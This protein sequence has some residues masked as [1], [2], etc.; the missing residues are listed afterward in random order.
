MPLISM[1]TNNSIT[2]ITLVDFIMPTQRTR[3]LISEI[4]IRTIQ[5]FWRRNFPSYQALFHRCLNLLEICDA[6]IPVPGAFLNGKHLFMGC[7][8][9]PALVLC[10]LT[11]LFLGLLRGDDPPPL[12]LL[13]LL[14]AIPQTSSENQ[15]SRNNTE[16][17]KRNPRHVPFR[18][19]CRD[20]HSVR[21]GGDTAPCLFAIFVSFVA[22][23]VPIY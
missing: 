8:L 16:Y 2:F 3:R 17:R 15:K 1:R 21:R 7:L 20:R 5:V 11:R 23:I 6:A 12:R 14:P 22:K 19:P 10:S 13:A 9:R 4:P 18:R